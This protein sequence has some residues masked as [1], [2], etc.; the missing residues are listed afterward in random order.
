M[1]YFIVDE[2]NGHY[3]ITSENLIESSPRFEWMKKN[4]ILFQDEDSAKDFVRTKL[5][6][7]NETKMQKLVEDYEKVENRV[8]FENLFDLRLSELS[9]VK[10][11]TFIDY[12][13]K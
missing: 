7:K 9:Y 5:E 2:V 1:K 10:L 13:K 11:K 8:D 12:L 6:D 3:I 4:R